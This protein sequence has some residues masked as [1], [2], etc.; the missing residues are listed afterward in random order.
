MHIPPARAGRREWTGLAVLALPTLLV[1]MDMTVMYLAVPVLSKVF[2]PGSAQLLWMTDIF[3]FLEAGCLITMGTLGDRIGRRRLLLTGAFAFTLASVFAAFSSSVTMLI[4]ARAVLGVAGATLLPS[5]LSLIRNMFR[6]EQQRSLAIGTWTT[7]FSAGTMLGPL[8]GGF[9]LSHFWW[10]SVFLMGGPVMLLFLVLGPLLLPEFRHTQEEHFDLLSA[11]LSM[12]AILF[13]IYGIKQIAEQ[14]VTGLPV[15]CICAGLCLAVLFL[16][17]QRRVQHPLIDLDLFR[18]PVFNIALAALLFAL[19]SWAGIFLFVTQHLQLVLGLDAF[20]AGLW[21]MPAAG[22]SILACMLTPVAARYIQRSWLIAGG[23]T[24]VA[25]GIILCSTAGSQHFP[26]FIAATVLLSG[27]CGFAVTLGHDRVLAAVAP[28]RAGAAAGI[29]ETGTSLGS[30]TG[31]ALL[32]SIGTA[33]YRSRMSQVVLPA[34]AP[35][36]AQTAGSTLGGARAVAGRLTGVRASL[37]LQQAQTAFEHS[38]RTAAWVAASVLLV[39]AVATVIVLRPK[40]K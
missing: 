20:T 37:L 4:V 16:R 7:C 10:G 30:A 33:V 25:A 32:G 40:K 35:G 5:T 19:F 1:S 38:F 17:R 27:G 12:A 18:S 34:V 11:G 22:G 14:G 9:L 13:I 28:E 39:V 36:D 29:A 24:V 2:Q 21:T 26:L 15:A 8:A 3:G 23:L 6:D 31:I